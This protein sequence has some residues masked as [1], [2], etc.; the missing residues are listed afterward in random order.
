MSGLANVGGPLSYRRRNPTR[1][2][3]ITATFSPTSPWFMH[4]NCHCLVH[5]GMPIRPGGRCPADRMP[6]AALGL[7]ATVSEVGDRRR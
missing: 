3:R 6:V 1:L 5:L 7:R 4:A 2:K